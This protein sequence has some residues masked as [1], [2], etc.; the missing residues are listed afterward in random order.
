MVTVV[1]LG[2]GCVGEAV[3]YGL[4]FIVGQ[5]VTLPEGWEWTAKVVNNPTFQVVADIAQPP[6]DAAPVAKPRGRPRKNV[7]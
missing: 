5:P 7:G 4:P 1:Y 3:V 6:A 2:D